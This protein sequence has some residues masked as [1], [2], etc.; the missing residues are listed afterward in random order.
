[1]RV[2]W[3]NKAT[4]LLDAAGEFIARDNPAAAGRVVERI[5]QSADRLADF[6]NM[7]RPGREDGTRELIVAGSPFILVYRVG[8]DVVQVLSVLHGAQ[9]WPETE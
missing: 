6:P 7:G 8:S 4:G 2:E 3:T 9:E 5:S 1:M